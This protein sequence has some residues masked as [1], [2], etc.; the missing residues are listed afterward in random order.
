MTRVRGELLAAGFEPGGDSVVAGSDRRAAVER[1]ARA[2]GSRAAI[3]VFA[4]PAPSRYG[5]PTAASGRTTVQT[6]ALEAG[7]DADA[8]PRCWR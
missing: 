6:F 4:R 2:R 3:G 5:S 8:A 1:E 7:G